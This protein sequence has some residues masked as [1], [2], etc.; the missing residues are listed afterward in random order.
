ME[1]ATIFYISKIDAAVKKYL[2]ERGLNEQ[3]IKEFRV[4]WAGNGWSDATDF[5]SKKGLKRR[6][7]L[8]AGIAV[9]NERG[10]C[11]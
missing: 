11:G 7:L 1:A 5:L 9:K 8:D 6:S 10:T 4:G 2:K 3:T